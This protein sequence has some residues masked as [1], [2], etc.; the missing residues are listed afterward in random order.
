M[1]EG[2]TPKLQD[3]LNPQSKRWTRIYPDFTAF[4]ITIPTGEGIVIMTPNV[5]APGVRQNTGDGLDDWR[6]DIPPGYLPLAGI[7]D[8]AQDPAEVLLYASN[9]AYT[10]ST[11]RIKFKN[12]SISPPKTWWKRLFFFA[13]A[14]DQF[15]F[16][17]PPTNYVSG[18]PVI[19]YGLNLVEVPKNVWGNPVSWRVLPVELW[20]PIEFKKIPL[21]EGIIKFLEAR[22][23]LIQ[24]ERSISAA[25]LPLEADRYGLE[26]NSYGIDAMHGNGI[27]PGQTLDRSVKMSA[28]GAEKAYD[29][30]FPYRPQDGIWQPIS[31]HQGRYILFNSEKLPLQDAFVKEDI[32]GTPP[33]KRQIFSRKVRLGSSVIDYN[34]IKPNPNFTSI[35]DPSTGS[36]YLPMG[37]SHS[38]YSVSIFK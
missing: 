16:F 27:I 38:A 29:L 6:V 5:C 23:E 14:P 22:V 9:H 36:L 13:D 20:L 1:A 21:E 15:A 26:I 34:Y 19:W 2:R 28:I 11:S 4:G 25:L 7:F 24:M 33:Q 37:E 31:E 30:L 17:G 32:Q 3:I 35:Y 12:I 10:S 18:K 8:N